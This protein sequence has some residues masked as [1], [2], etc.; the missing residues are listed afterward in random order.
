MDGPLIVNIETTNHCNLKCEYCP[1]KDM[2]RPKGYMSDEIFEKCVHDALEFPS[3]QRIQPFR[4]GEAFVDPKIYERVRYINEKAP[5]HIV[6][7]FSNFSIPFKKDEMSSW[8]PAMFVFSY[9]TN[10]DFDVVKTNIE[11]TKELDMPTEIHVVNEGGLY[12][13]ALAFGRDVDV[14]VV[15]CAKYNWAGKIPSDYKIKDGYCI[16]PS[17]SLQVLWDGRVDLC[18]MDVDGEVILG[19]IRENSL[20]EIW[21]SELAK[22][23]REHKKSE[24]DFCRNCNMQVK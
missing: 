15:G 18:C 6:V 12:E 13:S 16:R 10:V 19:D 23:Y 5:R 21:N 7:F 3:V 1:H 4:T 24:L 8:N 2:K 22:K 11:I 17:R 14:P 20:R 9:N